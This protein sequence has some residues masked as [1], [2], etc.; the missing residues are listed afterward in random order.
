MSEPVDGCIERYP[1]VAR[2]VVG[3]VGWAWPGAPPGPIPIHSLTCFNL[4]WGWGRAVVVPKSLPS[5][6]TVRGTDLSL[7]LF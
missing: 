3:E 1:V 4:R 7:S 2:T 6:L 5:T